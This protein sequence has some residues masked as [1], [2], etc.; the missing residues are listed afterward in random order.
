MSITADT[1]DIVSERSREE[2]SRT[3]VR[4]WLYLVLAVMFA[5][6]IVGGATRLTDSGLSITEW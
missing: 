6:F 5:L 3:L 1:A 4:W 2:R